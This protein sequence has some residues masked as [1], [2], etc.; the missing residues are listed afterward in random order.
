MTLGYDCPSKGLGTGMCQH[1]VQKKFIVVK[2]GLWKNM[3]LNSIYLK[4][5]LI[6]KFSLKICYEGTRHYALGLI[7]QAIQFKSSF[8]H[9][10][11]SFP[12][13]P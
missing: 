7:T 1:K 13:F 9:H 6:Y 12:S 10:T 4:N 5:T 11:S 8:H 2:F 3:L